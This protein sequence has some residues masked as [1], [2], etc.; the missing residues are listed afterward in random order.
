ML[1]IPP[2]GQRVPTHD[3]QRA[4]DSGDLSA[5]RVSQDVHPVHGR[6]IRYVFQDGSAI[7]KYTNRS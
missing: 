1:I 4:A 6:F 2:Q 7:I 3:A 5:A